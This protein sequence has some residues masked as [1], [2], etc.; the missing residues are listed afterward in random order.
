MIKSIKEI[1]K[2][3]FFNKKKLKYSNKGGWPGLKVLP[4][5][6]LL[7]DIGIGHQGTEG[8]YKFFPH[9]T[10]YFIDPLIET[11]DAVLVA[12]KQDSQ[13]L[14]NIVRQLNKEGFPEGQ[15]HNKVYRP[16]GY[17]LS[18]ERS[19]NWQ[20]KKIEVNPGASLSLQKH[21][22][23]SEY[24][25]VLKG[26]A[27]VKINE[28]EKYLLKNESIYIPLGS[29]HRLSNPGKDPLILIEVQSGDYLGED[30]I[31]RLE[32]NYGRN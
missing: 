9:S 4:Q 16:W 23:R 30:D 1:I 24:W 8:L 11:K 31:V 6:D 17:Y 28:K 26:K 32:D 25:I 7:I 29:I 22:H 5:V 14:K 12:A 15:Q 19:N 27:K 10:K 21:F 3:I 20:I 18:I 13:K 2:S